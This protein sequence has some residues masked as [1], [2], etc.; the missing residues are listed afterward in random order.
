MIDK[1][2]TTMGAEPVTKNFEFPVQS[3]LIIYLCFK[4]LI[5]MHFYGLPGLWSYKDV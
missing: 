4:Q 5:K 1:H 2:T 3:Y